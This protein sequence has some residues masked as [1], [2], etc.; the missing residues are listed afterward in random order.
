MATVTIASQELMTYDPDGASSPLTL[1]FPE[2]TLLVEGTKIAMLNI[3]N[4]STTIALAANSATPLDKIQDPTSRTTAFA[5]TH[6]ALTMTTYA[7]SEFLL[8]KTGVVN[9][10]WFCITHE[11][12]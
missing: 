7:Y 1:E 4:S 2:T 9:P 10:T 6:A 8:V 11:A 5:S 3:S 12:A